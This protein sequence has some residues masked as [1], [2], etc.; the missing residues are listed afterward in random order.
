MGDQRDVRGMHI[1]NGPQWHV[2]DC[3]RAAGDDGAV[4]ILHHLMRDDELT[5]QHSDIENGRWYSKVRIGHAPQGI[6][7]APN[8]LIH[9]RR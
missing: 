9:V 1:S 2:E 7:P 8:R 3:L 6:P 5:Q 4:T